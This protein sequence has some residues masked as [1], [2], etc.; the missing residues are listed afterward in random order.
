MK[1][2]FVRTAL[3][4]IILFLGVSLAASQ[5]QAPSAATTDSKSA[6]AKAASKSEK[7]AAA[8]ALLDI[9]T[10]TA[11]QLDALPGIGKA[12]SQKIIDGRPYKMKTDLV[13]KK[14]I[15]QATYDK[16]KGMIIAKQAKA[17]AAAVKKP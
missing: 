16:I 5:T 14:I 7:A 12:Y 15:P 3:A 17:S 8:S 11:E 13:R 4:A 6:Q 2:Q 1:K 10:A 9:N